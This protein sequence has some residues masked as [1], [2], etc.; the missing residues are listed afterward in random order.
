MD[1][2]PVADS[3]LAVSSAEHQVARAEIE[4]AESILPVAARVTAPLIICRI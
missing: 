4:P 3:A 1:V 2:F